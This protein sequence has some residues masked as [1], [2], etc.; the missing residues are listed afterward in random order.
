LL[1]FGTNCNRSS[2]AGAR[3]WTFPTYRPSFK[4]I[5]N[6]VLTIRRTGIFIPWNHEQSCRMQHTA[7]VM[8]FHIVTFVSLAES[9]FSLSS[10]ALGRRSRGETCTQFIVWF[11]TFRYHHDS[12]TKYRPL[13]LS[14]ISRQ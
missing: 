10:A 12:P 13:D 11:T 2:G 1:L 3:Q 8:V 7:L 14:W 5:P 9:H 4:T 6:Q